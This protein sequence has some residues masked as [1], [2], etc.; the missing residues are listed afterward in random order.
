MFLLILGVLIWAF[1][2]LFKRMAPHARRKMGAQGRAMVA[3]LLALSIVF[4]VIGY[5]T[6]YGEFFWGRTPMLVGVNNLLMLVSVYLF[7]AAGMKTK[8]AQNFRHP[9]LLGV[10][11]WSTAHLLVNGDTPSFVLFGGIG[12]WAL[13]EIALLSRVA[14]V[15]PKGK[16]A[17]MEVFALLGTVI[18][19]G[20]IAGVHYALG[21]PAFG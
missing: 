14:W 13:A 1:A 6:A 16:G 18:V 8:L 9:M 4:M 19:Y 7:A 5:H 10:V 12:L 15:P 2:H 3:G 11:M 21:H 17:K 20:A